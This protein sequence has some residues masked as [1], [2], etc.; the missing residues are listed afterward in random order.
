MSHCKL[1]LVLLIGGL[2]GRNDVLLIDRHIYICRQVFIEL[3]QQLLQHVIP[4]FP[5]DPFEHL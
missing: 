4:F 3:T 2:L 5:L 1:N